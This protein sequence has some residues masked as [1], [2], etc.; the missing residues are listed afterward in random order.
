MRTIGIQQELH[1]PHDT[2][3]ARMF[4]DPELAWIT[5]SALLPALV[6]ELVPESFRLADSRL[7]GPDL[8][9]RFTD[10]LFE[11]RFA[12]GEEVLIWIL[13][14]HKSQAEVTTAWQLQEYIG[15]IWR[16]HMAIAPNRRRGKLPLVVPVVVLHDPEG[17][18]LPKRFSEVYLGPPRARR[19]VARYVPD[20]QLL[21]D[22]LMA[23]KPEE[24]ARR[25]TSAAYRL[26]LW[27]L[28][29]RG[30]EPEERFE[31]YRKAWEE[32][33][34]AGRHNAITAL[35][36][37]AVAVSGDPKSVPVRAAQAVDTRLGE[38]AMGYG[39]KL[40]REGEEAGLKKGEEAGLKKGEEAGLKKGL[41]EGRKEAQVV[42]LLKL[43]TLRFGALP[44]ELEERIGR[45]DAEELGRWAEAVITSPDLAAFSALIDSAAR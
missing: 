30:E 11:A 13:F 24:I 33:W 8:S 22:D 29:S 5:L 42:L 36:R 14:E 17:R 20:F 16:E 44:P 4:R 27:L 7:V 18:R 21:V 45:A 39:M 6:A 26:T 40:Y 37:Y 1:A 35:L 31:D 25:S 38:E 34:V 23:L 2:L 12:D 9:D 19:A 28:R 43:A 32:L 41:E 15:H 10:I 3:F